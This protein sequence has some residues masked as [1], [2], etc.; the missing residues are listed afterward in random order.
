MIKQRKRNKKYESSESESDEE[1]SRNSSDDE[2]SEK[3]ENRCQECTENYYKTTSKE[4]WIKCLPCSFWIHEFCIMYKPLC[5]NC[6]RKAKREAIRNK[7]K[8]QP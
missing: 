8:S 4:D 2:I 7:K 5:N 3:D 6:C 1:E